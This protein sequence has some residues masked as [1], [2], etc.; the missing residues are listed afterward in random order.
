[1]HSS[2]L[3]AE[4]LNKINSNKQ[5][6]YRTK[7]KA[8]VSFFCAHF[9]TFTH[10]GEDAGRRKVK[11]KRK[12][13]KKMYTQYAHN[14]IEKIT[15]LHKP[16]ARVFFQTMI[17]ISAVT[18][19]PMYNAHKLRRVDIFFFAY[20]ARQREPY[21]VGT[22]S[23]AGTPRCLSITTTTGV[24]ASL[25]ISLQVQRKRKWCSTDNETLAC[26]ETYCV[27]CACRQLATAR[28]K[29][30]KTRVCDSEQSSNRRR[31]ER[32]RKRVSVKGAS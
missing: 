22:S 6:D 3:T 18:A 1:M 32:E 27:V 4:K 8:F 20:L 21:L 14:D 23:F 24:C 26:F 9:L 30:Q 31:R 29:K 2:H 13:K 19:S 25:R 16:W 17:T 12:K 5:G 28:K 7:M 10:C 11:L 15:S